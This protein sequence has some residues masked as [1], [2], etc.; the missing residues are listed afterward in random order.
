MLRAILFAEDKS[1]SL[2]IATLYHSLFKLVVFTLPFELKK[3][4]D[5]LRPRFTT[6]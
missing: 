3:E 1:W 2:A 6:Q 5:T 4:E